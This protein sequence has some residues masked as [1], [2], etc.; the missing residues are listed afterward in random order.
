MEIRQRKTRCIARQSNANLKK[1]KRFVRK[2]KR[3][4]SERRNVDEESA[5]MRVQRWGWPCLMNLGK[6]EFLNFRFFLP[7]FSRNSEFQNFGGL[8]KFSSIISVVNTNGRSKK[9]LL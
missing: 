3:A 5:R 6:L 9:I 2:S 7:F 8:A 4:E 1:L